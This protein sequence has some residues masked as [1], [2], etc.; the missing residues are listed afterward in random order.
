ML[1]N[2]TDDNDDDMLRL[3]T[4]TE[5]PAHGEAVI[6][7]D[8]VVYTM[9]PDYTGTSDTF[10]YQI[11]DGHG[12]ADVGTVEVTFEEAPPVH[13]PNRP[14]HLPYDGYEHVEV[15]AEGIPEGDYTATFRYRRPASRSRSGSSNPQSM[16]AC[17]QLAV[18]P[19]PQGGARAHP[20]ARQRPGRTPFRLHPDGEWT[21]EA[22]LTAVDTPTPSPDNGVSAAGTGSPE[23]SPT[24]TPDVPQV[25]T[26]PTTPDV[27]QV[28]TPPT[29]P[30]VPQVPTPSSDLPSV[31]GSPSGSPSLPEDPDVPSASPS[32]TPEV[33]RGAATGGLT[34]KGFLKALGIE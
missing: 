21:F 30:D 27:P 15:T 18:P 12:G 25:P 13:D 28:P 33:E 23:P 10:S 5:K 16:W 6:E 3:V 2:D 22:S 20:P 24:P 9:A 14:G 11:S 26:P 29:T 17:S 31:P 34:W 32:A 1:A 7:D 8:Q 19:V 4:I